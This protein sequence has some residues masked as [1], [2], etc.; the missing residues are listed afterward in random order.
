MP[1]RASEPNDDKMP[2]TNGQEPAST[3]TMDSVSAELALRVRAFLEREA[4]TQILKQVQEQT[5]VALGV[6]DDALER[7]RFVLAV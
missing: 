5:K 1:Q 2:I 3:K 7:Y 6:I 4:P